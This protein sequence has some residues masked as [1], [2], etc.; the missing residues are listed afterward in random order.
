MAYSLIDGLTALGAYGIIILANNS[1]CDL[2]K[3]RLSQPD[4]ETVFGVFI[5]LLPVV[6]VSYLAGSLGYIIVNSEVIMMANL[7]LHISLALILTIAVAQFKLFW[8]INSY[9]IKDKKLNKRFTPYVCGFWG[10]VFGGFLLS[11]DI[12]RATL[13]LSI[14][15]LPLISKYI[16]PNI[17]KIKSFWR[18]HN[19]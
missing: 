18:L 6:G 5:Y 10:A 7:K 11:L 14:Q 17:H 12:I 16:I 2:V 13:M 15:F 19:D 8:D 3:N 1:L 9:F 4:D